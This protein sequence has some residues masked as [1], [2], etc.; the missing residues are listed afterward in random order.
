MLGQE[1][2]MFFLLIFIARCRCLIFPNIAAFDVWA[3]YVILV[4]NFRLLSAVLG[5]RPFCCAVFL[6][7]CYY[8]QDWITRL[9]FLITDRP[10]NKQSMLAA[11]HDTSDYHR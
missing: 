8:L 6:F 7:R 2:S 9:R 5:H 11:S 1:L 4:I 3:H 10:V